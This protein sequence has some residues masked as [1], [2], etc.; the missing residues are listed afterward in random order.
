MNACC[1]A[2]RTADR[3]PRAH[4]H[5][6]QWQCIQNCMR[7]LSKMTVPSKQAYPAERRRR[8]AQQRTEARWMSCA[9]CW[10]RAARAA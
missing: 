9:T 8:G 10:R 3:E 6:P 5:A 7:G 2:L 4:L 1:K